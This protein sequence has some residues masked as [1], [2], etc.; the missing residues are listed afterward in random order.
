MQRHHRW[1]IRR[2]PEPEPGAGV[3][4]AR[5]RSRRDILLGSGAGA[6]IVPWVPGSGFS[7]PELEPG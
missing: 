3:G 5:S 4:V 2:S 6:G 7:D 1:C